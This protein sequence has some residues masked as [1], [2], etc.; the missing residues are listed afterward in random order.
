[1]NPERYICAKCARPLEQRLVLVGRGC[2]WLWTCPEDDQDFSHYNRARVS[3]QEY[4]Q[5]VALFGQ[6]IAA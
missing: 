4:R 3:E 5:A 6:R 1:M 2:A